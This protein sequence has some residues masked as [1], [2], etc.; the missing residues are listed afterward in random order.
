[1]KNKKGFTLVE[2]MI[3]IVI[4]GLLAAMIV[5]TFFA[6]RFDSQIRDTT[7]IVYE[8]YKDNYSFG[9]VKHYSNDLKKTFTVKGFEPLIF[10]RELRNT[11]ERKI[12]DPRP[13][14]GSEKDVVTTSPTMLI[15]KEEP[16]SEYESIKLKNKVSSL[17]NRIENLESELRELKN[18]KY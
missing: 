10:E 7:K 16:M 3:V 11:L 9:E 15:E 2:T 5:P 18:G 8:E 14:I 13:N 6:V 1:M 12:R 17:E 4:V